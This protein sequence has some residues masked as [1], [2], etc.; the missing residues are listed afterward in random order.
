MWSVRNSE[1][2]FVIPGFQIHNILEFETSIVHG[3]ALCFRYKPWRG[4][5]PTLLAVA[6]LTRYLLNWNE[7]HNKPNE[8][9]YCGVLW[10]ITSS[11]SQD[12]FEGQGHSFVFFEQLKLHFSVITNCSSRWTMQRKIIYSSYI[13]LFGIAIN[14]GTE[15]LLMLVERMIN[16]MIA[17]KIHPITT[18]TQ[19]FW[20]M[21]YR[22]TNL[23]KKDACWK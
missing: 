11:P 12:Q 21:T 22:R 4:S 23:T 10:E 16:W 5:G 14:G 15:S 19:C 3:P 17:I 9:R 13:K 1:V 8:E 18:G 7:N 20:F 6:V 2:L